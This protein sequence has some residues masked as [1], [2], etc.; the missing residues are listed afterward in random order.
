MSRI[1]C[2]PINDGQARYLKGEARRIIMKHYFHSFDLCVIDHCNLSCS[3]CNH[4]SPYFKEHFVSLQQVEE[5]VQRLK[6]VIFTE[7]IRI[8]GGEP[9]LHL[10][11]A[12]ILDVV[13]TSGMADKITIISNGTLIGRMS[14]EIWK[15]IDRLWIDH[16][17]GVHYGLDEESFERKAKEH[18]VGVWRRNIKFFGIVALNQINPDAGLVQRIYNNCRMANAWNCAQIRD[19]YVY[20]CSVAPN[21]SQKLS[22]LGI[23]LENRQSDGI[24]IHEHT[25]F[26]MD[27]TRYFMDK[28]PLRACHYCLGTS[29]KRRVHHQLHSQ[30]EELA[31][32]HSDVASLI[33]VREYWKSKMTILFGSSKIFHAAKKRFRYVRPT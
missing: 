32:D 18:K 11:L 12:A 14:D 2:L 27:L 24:P 4:F 26:E 19:G 31:E 13:R 5:D 22:F 8:T 6:K 30:E 29:G 28:K 3:Q 23:S 25:N 7:E 16:Y 21:I 9:L 33:S 1:R 15:R 17:P 20:K 10:D